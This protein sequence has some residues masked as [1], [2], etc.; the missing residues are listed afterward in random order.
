MI[1][2]QKKYQK[3]EITKDV[4]INEMYNYHRILF[5]Y[6]EFI[7]NNDIKKIEILDNKVIMTSRKL[8][9]KII[10]KKDDE[11]IP[12]IET[13]NFKNYEQN[14]AD[15]LYSLMKD[16]FTIFDVGA[17]IGWYSIGLSKFRKNI[18][19]FAFEPIP[20]TYRDLERNV[21]LN[22]TKNIHIFNY[23]LS[24]KNDDLPFYYYPE[25]SAN[26]SSA[27]MKE[28]D[29]LQIIKCKVMTLDKFVKDNKIKKIDFI[30]CDVEGGEFF[31]FKGGERSIEKFKPIIFS[32]MLR[33][34]S[35][36]FGYHP[37]KIIKLLKEKGYLCF[38]VS[39][40]KLKEIKKITE[41]TIETNF[42]F[43]HNQKHS[44]QILKY[45]NL[46]LYG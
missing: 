13:L 40:N 5:N 27:L 41:N 42:F 29:N 45:G 6:S 15:M 22:K 33:K 38:I 11:R 1:E 30:K 10:C 2:I 4:Y 9:I 21:I 8:E 25:C 3:G 36:K 17:N 16:N 20:N 24:D 31:V 43:L 39:N 14:D 46:K 26:A 35:A 32:E 28:S 18:E 19:V 12:P 37:N 34:W 23:G 44:S 7:C